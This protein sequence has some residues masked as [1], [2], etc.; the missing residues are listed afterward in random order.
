MSKYFKLYFLFIY[1]IVSS[2]TA[3]AQD[4]IQD[5]LVEQTLRDKE[6]KEIIVN[7]DYNYEDLFS[8]P[9]KLQVSE[10]ITTKHNIQEG[11]VINLRVKQIVKY[12]EKVILNQNTIVKGKIKVYTTKGMNGIPGQI[13][14]DDF[15]LPGIDSRKIKGTFTKRGLDLTLYVLPIKW[16]LTPIPFVGSFTNLI[17]G[18]SA[19]ITPRDTIILYYY[20]N[21]HK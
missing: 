20:P 4:L 18:G 8:I 14:L 2:Y 9:I 6:I 7:A 3:C 11:D 19:E 16:A 13:V 10:K 21:W 17:F 5:E 12:N 15:E 1:F